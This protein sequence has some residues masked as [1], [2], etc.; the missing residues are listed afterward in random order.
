MTAHFDIDDIA[1]RIAVQKP[2]FAFSAL[3]RDGD[4]LVGDFVPEQELGGELGYLSAAELGRH[5]AILGS[6]AA[7]SLNE[8]ITGYYLATKALYT[9]K[10][11]GHGTAISSQPRPPSLRASAK[12]L[13]LDKRSLKIAATAYAH[14]PIAELVCEYFILPPA[15]FQRSFKTY[16]DTTK[17][18]PSAS[19]PYR[20]RIPLNHVE[21]HAKSLSAY[22]GPLQPE[23]CAGHFLHYPSWPVAI[24]AHTVFKTN[25]A[26][27]EQVYGAG[28][29]YHVVETQLSAD[30]LVSAR[31]A[32]RFVTEIVEE[33]K[34]R[35]TTQTQVFREEEQVA[36]FKSIFDLLHL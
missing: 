23:Q 9:G 13:S 6:C 22:S 26:L 20:K 30:K 5:L 27:F 15:L 2:Y 32:L 36:S 12:V 16:I 35:V 4:H 7:V 21:Y 17:P 19:S 14:Q 34:N 3:W 11:S 24:I 33:E 29:K 18:M 1:Q 25:E 8:G 28:T 10:S 31:T